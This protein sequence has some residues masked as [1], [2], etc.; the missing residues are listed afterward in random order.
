MN[1]KERHDRIAEIEK[2]QLSNPVTEHFEAFI[3]GNAMRVERVVEEN[4]HKGQHL[5]LCGAGPSLRD[6]ADEWCPK[7]DAV[8][9][10]NSALTWLHEHGH[11]PTHGFSVD[12]TPAM[13][14]EWA[15]PPDVEYL[16]AS[17][18]HPYLVDH[19]KHNERTMRFFNNYVGIRKPP[20]SYCVCGHDK[21]EHVYADHSADLVCT[22][23]DC[24]E[25]AMR[26]MG[27][28]DWLYAALSGSN[29]KFKATIRAG[30]GLNAVTR[31]V[32]VAQYMGF[33]KITVLGADC[34]LRVKRPFEG[35]HGSAEHHA[36]LENETEMHAD[37]G[38]ALSS[39]ATPVTYGGEIDGRWWETKPDMLITAVW[40]VRM[41]KSLGPGFR[42][43][44]DTLPNA[45]RDKEDAFLDDLAAMLDSEGKPIQYPVPKVDAP[46]A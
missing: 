5:I 41:L 36:W 45:L 21:V 44:G 19:L 18:V 20:V 2:I 38:N 31:A 30:S 33:S 14:N 34:A 43:V 3:A 29:P 22:C 46:T 35:A 32:D 10:C 9:G 16:I 23:C 39:G 11:N 42:L 12:Q 15:E 8:W 40:L 28:E 27:Y 1:S 7:G 17:T 6:E 26:I 4:S 25:Y 24:E 37:G 13:V